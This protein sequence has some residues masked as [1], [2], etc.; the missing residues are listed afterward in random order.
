MVKD[1]L[2]YQNHHKKG[3]PRHNFVL[4]FQETTETKSHKIKL[5]KT[6]VDFLYKLHHY[7]K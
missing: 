2:F 4:E 1:K 5:T 7:G 6:E 3:N